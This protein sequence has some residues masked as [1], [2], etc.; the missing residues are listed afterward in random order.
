VVVPWIS[1]P[2]RWDRHPQVAP[3]FMLSK[4]KNTP[5][6][7]LKSE[8]VNPGNV[9]SFGWLDEAPMPDLTIGNTVRSTIERIKNADHRR[10]SP[11][12]GRD[13]QG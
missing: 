7:E 3:I 8:E 1:N 5:N 10:K 2:E 9:V 4:I 11:R 12:N 6:R 13:G